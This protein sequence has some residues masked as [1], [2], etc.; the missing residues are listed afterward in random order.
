MLEI[1]LQHVL[2][3]TYVYCIYV[4]N[5]FAICIMVYPVI[6]IVKCVGQVMQPAFIHS[7]VAYAIYDREFLTI[8]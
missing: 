4:Y 5:A 2:L 8:Y 3:G 6:C 1:F 7:S